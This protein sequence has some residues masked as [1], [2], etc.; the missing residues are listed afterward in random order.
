MYANA[1]LTLKR[2]LPL[3]ILDGA[4]GIDAGQCQDHRFRAGLENIELTKEERSSE[5]IS[6]NCV[7]RC[8]ANGSTSMSPSGV[9]VNWDGLRMECECS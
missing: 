9:V 8:E 5:I 6:I 1:T 2:N 3:D 7:V 4:V